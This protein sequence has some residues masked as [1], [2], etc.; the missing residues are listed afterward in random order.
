MKGSA[1]SL[2]AIFR[3][4][5]VQ[6]LTV[7]LG[8]AVAGEFK[9]NPVPGDLFRIALGGSAFLLLLLLMNRLPYLKAGLYTGITVVIFRT[10]LDVIFAPASFHLED[11]LRLHTSSGLYYLTFA[12]GLLAL[13]HRIGSMNALWL[14]ACCAA[15]DL[16]SNV[17]E[18]I[19][20]WLLNGSDITHPATWGY[21]ALVGL[22]RGFF[23][24]GLYSSI[25]VSQIRALNLEQ[26]KRMEQMLAVNSGLYGEVFYLRKSMSAME[27]VTRD[28]YRLY[29]DLKREGLDELGR[30]QLK[31]TQELHEIKKDSQRIAAG[32]LKLFD[33][34]AKTL[35]TLSEI[36]DY[37]LRGNRKYA[38]ML[39]K[40]ILFEVETSS[41]YATSQHL[42]LLSLLNNLLANAVEAIDRSGVIGLEIRVEGADT[43]LIVR[44]TGRGIPDKSRMLVFEPGFTTKFGEGGAAA[45]GIGLSH[46]HDIVH[47]LGGSVRLLPDSEEGWITVFEAVIPTD[48]LKKEE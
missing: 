14:G 6:L 34:E 22:A 5:K 21:I 37:A 48:R 31:V 26:S 13:Q 10:L 39:G 32:L 11:S 35:L 36:A 41:S 43:R 18:M 47:E 42:A 16:T 1:G 12:F 9:I 46:V 29:A 20:R 25:A 17:V 23:V 33:Q 3:N 28:S 27:R 40:W 7:A 2:Y 15:I 4:E 45:T 8:T 38:A 30:R 44:D 19:C 24:T